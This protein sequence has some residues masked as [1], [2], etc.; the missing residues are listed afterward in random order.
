MSNLYTRRLL[1]ISSE[2]GDVD[3]DDSDGYGVFGGVAADA[4]SLIVASCVLAASVVIWEACAFAVM[5]AALVAGATW[6]LSIATAS[7]EG[8][9]YSAAA[10][11]RHGGACG[12]L[13]EVEISRALP[14]SPYQQIHVGW[15]VARRRAPCAW[16]RSDLSPTKA[17]AAGLRQGALPSPRLLSL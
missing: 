17:A 5:A 1:A 15:R 3:D 9:E 10:P 13:A 4:W 14:A 2:A 7:R 12:G 6:C 16:R 8:I 11:G